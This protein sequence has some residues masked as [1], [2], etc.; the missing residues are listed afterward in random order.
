MGEEVGTGEGGLLGLEEG[1]AEGLL[2][3]L[4][5]GEADGELLGLEDGESEGELLGLELGEL[6]GLAEGELL[7]LELGWRVGPTEIGGREREGES[8]EEGMILHQKDHVMSSIIGKDAKHELTCGPH[9]WA[10][11]CGSCRWS[12]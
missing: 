3:G 5:L 9:G 6:L 4:E 10:H 11:E 12:G 2:L 7:G 1:E 8:R